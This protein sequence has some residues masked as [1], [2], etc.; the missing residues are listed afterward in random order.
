[1]N[2]THDVDIVSLEILQACVD[3]GR[4]AFRAV[5]GGIYHNLALTVFGAEVGRVFG[6]DY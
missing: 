2:G 5:A 3:R 1:V 6:C 4:Q